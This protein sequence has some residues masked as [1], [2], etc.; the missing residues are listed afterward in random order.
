MPQRNPFG[1]KNNVTGSARLCVF[2]RFMTPPQ[3]PRNPIEVM[4]RAK[5]DESCRYVN[6]LVCSDALPASF[7]AG[8]EKGMLNRRRC[9]IINELI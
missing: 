1:R 4:R 5:D 2:D 7:P 8:P 3:S 6:T 9:A